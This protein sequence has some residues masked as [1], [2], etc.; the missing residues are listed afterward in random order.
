MDRCCRAELWVCGEKAAVVWG[1]R[2]S[3]LP[4]CPPCAD[5]E[6]SDMDVVHGVSTEE[7]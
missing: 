7:H 2:V 5:D 6:G 3:A 4:S 1:P